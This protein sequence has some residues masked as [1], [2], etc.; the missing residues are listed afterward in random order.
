M[1]F[2]EGFYVGR[3]STVVLTTG[4]NRINI[5]SGRFPRKEIDSVTAY[6]ILQTEFEVCVNFGVMTIKL[7]K[8]HAAENADGLFLS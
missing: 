1:D 4:I 8:G 5:H 7:E 3:K 6:A 2:L